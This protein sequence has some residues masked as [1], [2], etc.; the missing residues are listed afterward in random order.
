MGIGNLFRS[1]S[2]KILIFGMKILQQHLNIFGLKFRAQGLDHFA[3]FRGGNF[4]DLQ[5]LDGAPQLPQFSA[6]G[7][8]SFIKYTAQFDARESNQKN[9]ALNFW[10]MIQKPFAANSDIF[11]CSHEH[12][13]LKNQ[14]FSHFSQSGQLV[15]PK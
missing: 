10:K 15:R 14:Y 6:M 4:V 7:Q 5:V 3:Q 13:Q 1:I 2:H 8:T 12:F 11:Q 9:A